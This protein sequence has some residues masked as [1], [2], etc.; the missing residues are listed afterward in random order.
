MLTVRLVSEALAN[1][2]DCVSVRSPLGMAVIGLGV[3]DEADVQIDGRL[4]TV[5]LE[6][7]ESDADNVSGLVEIAPLLG[8]KNQATQR[9]S[10]G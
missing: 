2:R 10:V 6:Q 4:R 7:I 1:G 3:E 5:V 8:A 9:S